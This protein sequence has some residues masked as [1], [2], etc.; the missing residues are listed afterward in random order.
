MEWAGLF[1]IDFITKKER[2][3]MM[4]K[5]FVSE[6]YRGA[7]AKMFAVLISLLVAF[8]VTPKAEAQAPAD[9]LI[10]STSVTDGTDSVEAVQA[11]LSGFTVEVATPAEWAA[12][13]TEDFAGYKAIV[14]GDPTCSAGLGSI[15]AAIDNRDVWG[16]AITGNVL[17]LG[18][19]PVFHQ[20]LA[21]AVK[22]IKQGIEFAASEPGRTGA[23]I[24]LSCYYYAVSESE[25]AHV[26]VLEP[27]GDFSVI[28]Q[29]SG[30][31]GDS[32][33]VAT[34]PA[35]EGLTDGDLSYWGCTFHE[36]FVTWPITFEVLVIARDVPSDYVAPDGSSGAPYIIGRGV[37]V[38]SDIDLSPQT[39][40]NTLSMEHT[41]IATVMEDDSPVVGTVVTFGVIDGP[42]AG[43][44]GQGVTDASG[45]AAFTYTATDV[46]VDFIQATFVDSEDR[47]Q[48]SNKVTKEWIVPPSLHIPGGTQQK[49]YRLVGV[50]GI[51]T[52][53]LDALAVFKG[54]SSYDQDQIRIFW[55]NPAR[56]GYDEYDKVP[57]PMPGVGFMM[58]SREDLTPT[59]Y[60]DLIPHDRVF[61]VVLR[62]RWNMPANPFVYGLPGGAVVP[63]KG[64][65]SMEQPDDGCL[66]SVFYAYNGGWVPVTRENGWLEP[67]Q[68]IA[69][70]N[71]C[72]TDI[73]LGFVPQGL[74]VSAEPT[75][76]LGSMQQNPVTSGVPRP[77]PEASVAPVGISFTLKY[78]RYKDRTLFL[79]MHPLASEKRD[80]MDGLAPPPGPSRAPKIYVDH[81]DWTYRPGAYAVDI[82]RLG[83]GPHEF[84]LTV[85][86]PRIKSKAKK[87]KLTWR[88]V[89]D[90]PSRLKVTLVDEEKGRSVDMR[91]KR[92]YKIKPRKKATHYELKVLID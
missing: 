60:G 66:E 6:R 90:I 13:S 10:L 16:P 3:S 21:G 24:C 81:S 86:L 57:A 65:P 72:D 50:P 59:F 8:G 44:T 62:P 37:Q 89:K 29:G 43:I 91:R 61:V 52:Y 53:D 32:H 19:D 15:Q 69:V 70:Y 87:C 36:G 7:R 85:E 1:R 9:I 45:Q 73:L 33:I 17:V 23:Y 82:R 39:A 42:H 26:T 58:I 22:L 68:G 46:G 71:W 12:K 41:V 88:G 14:L 84:A 80:A 55:Y 63:E 67:G 5:I 48:T 56:Q 83:E 75:A 47:T 2:V 76:E 35:L 49:D 25:P 11:G 18:T 20:G 40:V 38:I 79:G 27:F 77:S 28:G 54:G 4:V 31:P 34:H 64:V 51:I 74:G 78:K 30:C 92:R